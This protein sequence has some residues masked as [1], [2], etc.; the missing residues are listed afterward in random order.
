MKTENNRSVA[1]YSRKLQCVNRGGGGV[2]EWVYGSGAY[3]AEVYASV[4]SH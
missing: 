4:H 2:G 1:G 3:V